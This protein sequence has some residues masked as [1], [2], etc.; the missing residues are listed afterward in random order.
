MITKGSS[1]L[2]LLDNITVSL[3]SYTFKYP[4]IMQLKYYLKKM[5]L[6]VILLSVALGG[7]S[8][9]DEN[10]DLEE[11][12]EKKSTPFLTNEEL[13]ALK[14][15]NGSTQIIPEDAENVLNDFCQN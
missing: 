12:T 9:Y 1:F 4:N 11:L 13:L 5:F 7:C 2:L 10:S 15:M 14:L 6:F 8:Q 3:K